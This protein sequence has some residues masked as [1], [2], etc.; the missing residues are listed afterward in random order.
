MGL[1]LGWVDLDFDV[2]L[3]RRVKKA[4]TKTDKLMECNFKVPDVEY[5]LPS[6]DS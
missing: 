5:A 6:V 1:G 2:P 3:Y 4:S